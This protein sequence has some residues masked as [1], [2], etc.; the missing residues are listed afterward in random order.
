MLS[1]TLVEVA[2]N[3][4]R[5]G[6]KTAK[7]T[8]AAGAHTPLAGLVFHRLATKLIKGRGHRQLLFLSGACAVKMLVDGEKR[9]AMDGDGD[10]MRERDICIYAHVSALANCEFYF[11]CSDWSPY[12]KIKKK[13]LFYSG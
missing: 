4:T 12:K 7:I 3:I 2:G 6:G 9:A 8:V 13:V 5:D 10:E 11:P 1:S